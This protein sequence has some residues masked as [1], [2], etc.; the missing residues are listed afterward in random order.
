MRLVRITIGVLAMMTAAGVVLYLLLDTSYESAAMY[1]NTGIGPDPN[2]PPTLICL[3]RSGRVTLVLVRGE[4]ESR[5]GFTDTG[6]REIVA[7]DMPRPAA[8]DR[9]DLSGADVRV[10]YRKSQ[11][12]ISWVIGDG[13]VRGHIHIR[14]VDANRIVASYE[15]LIDAFCERNIPLHQH[16]DVIFDGRSTFSSAAAANGASRLGTV[17]E[18]VETMRRNHIRRAAASRSAEPR[19]TRLARSNRGL[20]SKR[21]RVPK[22]VRL[23]SADLLARSSSWFSS[24]RFACPSWSA[25]ARRT[26]RPLRGFCRST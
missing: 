13:G 11:A 2:D 6:W 23:G 7:I 17:A 21:S 22:L 14:S 4:G 18:A 25:S 20:S 24:K 8:G 3:E 10:G 5:L 19:R 26:Y 16:R 15:I 9:I 1:E 12:F